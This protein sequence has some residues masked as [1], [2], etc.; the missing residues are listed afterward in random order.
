MTVQVLGEDVVESV[1][2]EAERFKSR[3]LRYLG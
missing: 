3:V 1:V 2:D